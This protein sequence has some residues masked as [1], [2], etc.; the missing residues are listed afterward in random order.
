M[1]HDSESSTVA[2]ASLIQTFNRFLLDQMTAEA[3]S[4][5]YNPSLLKSNLAT[6]GIKSPVSQLLAL[7]AKTL[8]I[9][10]CG[11]QTSRDSTLSVVDMI[12]PRRAMSNETTPASDFATIVRNSLSRESVARMTCS[13]CRQSH[14]LRIKRILSDAAPLPPVLIMNAGVRTADELEFWTD[15]RQGEGRRFLESRFYIGKETAT[16]GGLVVSSPESSE[17][18]TGVAVYELRVSNSDLLLSSCWYRQLMFGFQAMVVQIQA[19]GDPPHLVAVAR[20]TLL[21]SSPIAWNEC[22]DPYLAYSTK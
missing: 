3:D 19:E 18:Q 17:G 6:T 11:G 4:P 13:T 12:Y 9:C 14:H 21:S 5:G 10:Q 2:Y 7:E 1:D 8:S 22:P 15:G 16:D 20:G